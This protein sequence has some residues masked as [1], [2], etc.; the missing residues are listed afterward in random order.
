VGIE[1]TIS[2]VEGKRTLQPPLNHWRRHKII[3]WN[4]K[5]Q[6]PSHWPAGSPS[7]NCRVFFFLAHLTT[8]TEI[9]FA[10][11]VACQR[12][13]RVL[14]VPHEPHH[15]IVL[16]VGMQCVCVLLFCV[17][18]ITLILCVGLSLHVC[19]Y[20]YIIMPATGI[21]QS[22]DS[23]I[24][25]IVIC[26]YCLMTLIAIISAGSELPAYLFWETTRPYDN[27]IPLY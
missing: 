9:Q 24:I 26:V 16:K 22:G 25:N 21:S 18:Y 8:E 27:I 5:N 15:V 14:F 3:S 4:K 12:T 20:T 2:R 19:S 7:F 13:H 10:D 11:F 6:P 1:P 17:M 23:I